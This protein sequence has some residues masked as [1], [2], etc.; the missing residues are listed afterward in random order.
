MMSVHNKIYTQ[1]DLIKALAYALQ[2]KDMDVLTLCSE[3]AAG[4]IVDKETKES[5]DLLIASILEEIL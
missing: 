5:Y 1:N 3:T 2:R 4:W